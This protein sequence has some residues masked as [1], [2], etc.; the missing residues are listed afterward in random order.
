[1]EKELAK[2]VGDEE[3]GIA[4]MW[5][6]STGKVEVVPWNPCCIILNSGKSGRTSAEGEILVDEPEV[7]L[8]KL[9]DVRLQ[10]RP[11][12][13]GRAARPGGGRLAR[14][15]EQERVEAGG[16]DAGQRDQG[17]AQGGTLEESSFRGS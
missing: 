5:A 7:Q 14:R 10:E 17:A 15:Q 3:L 4:L 11:R 6:A 13:G 2:G 9:P 16:G 1:M 8:G 12:Q